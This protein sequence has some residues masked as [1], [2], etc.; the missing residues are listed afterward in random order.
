MSDLSPIAKTVADLRNT[1]DRSYS[2]PP[3][4]SGAEQ[5]ENLLAL[6]LAGNPYAIRVTE[7]A[8]L[9]NNRKT[10]AIPSPISELLGVAG[11]RGGLVPVYSLAALLGYDRNG[12]ARD[13]S[14]ARW[15]ALCGNEDQ[16]GL[17]FSDLEGYLRV[18]AVQIYAAS[19]E[20]I[21]GGHVKDVARVDGLVRPVV[22]IPSVVEMIQ[23]RCGEIR[24]SPMQL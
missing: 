16:V 6:R 10:V 2:L 7:I 1:F 20:N 9:V 8:G 23:R 3:S 15:L 21:M 4:S 12:Y 5:V 18:P 19:Q 13:A 22:S 11:I 17:G 24:V 14:P